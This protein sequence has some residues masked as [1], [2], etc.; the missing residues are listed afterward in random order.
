MLARPRLGPHEGREEN[1]KDSGWL[2]A[3]E[4]KYF[5]TRYDVD[6]R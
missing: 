2:D 1:Q 3:R 4:E 5:E 6:S